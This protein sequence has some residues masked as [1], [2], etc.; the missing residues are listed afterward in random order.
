MRLLII[1]D[2]NGQ[3]GA[4]SK[5]ARAR[6]AKVG[7][8]SD[9]D[10]A[11]TMLCEG[12]GADLVMIQ[13]D[14]D[15]ARFV[16]MLESERIHVIIVACGIDSD[17]RAAVRAIKAGAKE[18]IPLPPDEELIAAVFEAISEE[19]N[20]VIHGSDAMRQVLQIADQVAQSDASVLITGESGTGKE[21]IARYI[22]KKS[23]RATKPFISLNCAAIPENLLESELFGHEKGSFTGAISRRLGKF[24]EANTGTLLLDEISEMALHLQSKLLRAIQE[25]EIVRVGSNKP[26]KVNIR[27]LATSNRDLEAH[28]R[29]GLFREDLYFR[30]NVINLQ[31]PSLSNRIG[32]IEP[33]SSYFIEKYSKANGMPIRKLSEDALKKLKSHSWPGNV[34]ELENICHRA[35][36]MAKGDVI[37]ADA[38]LIQNSNYSAVQAEPESAAVIAGSFTKDKQAAKPND[39]V[40]RT[41]ADVE[42][43]LILDTLDHCLGNRTHAANILGIS[44][45]TLRNKLKLYSDTD[46]QQYSN[47]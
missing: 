28:V 14:A 30:L 35:V 23:D 27:I 3:I 1:G 39:L 24:E 13:A 41:V 20:S 4:A 7:Q 40:G 37:S 44:I 8:V 31:L 21:V 29:K 18:Y 16:Q 22:H 5:I 47:G 6:G 17:S 26:V 25:R 45:R 42:R 15:I 34:R 38:V 36:L 10:S 33:L 19:T 46:G 43:D 32:D 9:I 2:L 11:F 12:Q